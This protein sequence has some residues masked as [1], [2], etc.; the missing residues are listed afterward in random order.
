MQTFTRI[1]LFLLLL[2]ASGA[3]QAFFVSASTSTSSEGQPVTQVAL[4]LIY[5]ILFVIIMKKYRKTALFFIQKEKWTLIICLWA[6]ASTVWSAGPGGTLRHAL[7]L[8]GTSIA[9]LYIGMR[10]EPKQQLKMFALVIGLGAIASL[11]AGLLLP[12][13]GFTPDG[14][15]Q[16]VYHLKN[17]LGRMMALGVL[18]LGIQILDQ[19]RHRVVR[20]GM[21]L[22]CCGLLFLSQ[23][24]TAVVVTFLML[25]MLP[26]RKFLYL[27]VRPLIILATVVALFAATAG[28]WLF[29]NSDKLFLALGRSSSLTGRIPLWGYVVNEI[30]A[31]PLLGYGF[32]AFW[33]SWEGE[34]VSDAVNW[35]AAVPHAHNGF[36]E[37]WL[38]LGIIGL[39]FLLMSFW[40]NLRIGIRVAKSR[41]A[42]D[43]SWPLLF[44]AFTVFYNF[45]ETSFLGSNSL[46]WM[47]YVANSFWL[48]RT[49]EEEKYA[50]E[51]NEELE[52]AYSA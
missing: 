9:G 30:A 33:T 15:W 20:V 32:T 21:F 1:L 18:C 29:E 10:Y 7:A 52:P 49:V 23:S 19:R 13:V 24:A 44:L 39:A 41:P 40:S 6:L 47:A 36:L 37:I 27:R 42:L 3:G 16:G 22:L 51:L 4:S 46:L 11:A 43:Q 45:T 48:I 35:E 25:A 34:R 26:F 12:G 2:F 31:R 8:V 5:L 14:S 28:F 50:S 17:A 38:G